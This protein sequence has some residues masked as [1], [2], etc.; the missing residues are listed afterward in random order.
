M[1]GEKSWRKLKRNATCCLKQIMETTPHKIAT[2]QQLVSHLTNHKIKTNKIWGHCWRS[3]D[4]LIMFHS[5]IHVHAEIYIYIY[6][7]TGYIPTLWITDARKTSLE[8]YLHLTILQGFEKVVWSFTV[9][10]SWK[11]NINCNILIPLLWPSALCLSRSPVLLNRRPRAHSDGWWLSLLHFISIFS[12]PQLIR[13]Q[14][15]PSAWCG[16]P[17]HISSLSVWSPTLLKLELGLEL[18]WHLTSVLLRYIIIQRPHD[19]PL[20]LWN[21]MFNRH[22]AEITVMQFKGN[23]FPVHQSMCV[24]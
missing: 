15:A 22:Q 18:N 23:S 7:Y 14:M 9:R 2:Q 4:E 10:G 16:F 24:P 1:R 20:D 13:A 8:K 17:Y 6:I 11:P 5:H 21:R 3:R 12:G 19:R